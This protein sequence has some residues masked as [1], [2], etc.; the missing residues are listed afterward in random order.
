MTLEETWK[1]AVCILDIGSVVNS[2]G[3]VHLEMVMMDSNVTISLLIFIFNVII[4]F[5]KIEIC[6]TLFFNLW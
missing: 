2:K 6:S 5:N 3:N 1:L 4:F